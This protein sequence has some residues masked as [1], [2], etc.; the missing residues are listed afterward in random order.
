ME[1]SFS[2]LI[3]YR[4]FSKILQVFFLEKHC[5]CFIFL[6]SYATGYL[7]WGYFI[8]YVFT[9]LIGLGIL[10]IRLFF[11]GKFWTDTILKLVPVIVAIIIKLIINNVASK[12][13]F[14]NRNSKILAIDN[15]R[16]FNVFLY[17]N[18][19]FDCFMGVVSA[20]TRLVKSFFLAIFMLPSNFKRCNF[21]P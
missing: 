7:I 10:F 16:A 9:L 14:L 18:F 2:N 3:L 1:K 19:F 6:I 21:N 12:F 4:I 20:I 8:I 13:I 17:F 11:P 15:F 5:I